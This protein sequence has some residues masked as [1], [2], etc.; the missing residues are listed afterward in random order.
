MQRSNLK[1]S[2]TFVHTFFWSKK[3]L[4]SNNC[5]LIDFYAQ[6]WCNLL[7]FREYFEK[8]KNMS[9]C[10]NACQH[11]RI[12]FLKFPKPTKLFIIQFINSFA[13]LIVTSG[14]ANLSNRAAS[15]AASS[16]R[17]KPY[18]RSQRWPSA[19][20]FPAPAISIFFF[21]HHGRW[22][23]DRSGVGEK[24]PYESYATCTKQRKQ[25]KTVLPEN[26][27]PHRWDCKHTTVCMAVKSGSGMPLSLPHKQHAEVGETL[28]RFPWAG[29]TNQSG[30]KLP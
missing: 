6:F 14:A 13:A 16:T 30:R 15:R 24:K 3:H 21:P 17:N 18:I 28:T 19:K 1:N 23:Y 2:T 27:E 11:L 9:I 10:R 7:N 12:Y 20:S 25:W 22:S 26:D 29:V 8:L 4:F 5:H